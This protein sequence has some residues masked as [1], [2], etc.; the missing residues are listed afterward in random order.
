LFNCAYWNINRTDMKFT[1]PRELS[2]AHPDYQGGCAETETPFIGANGKTFLYVW[3][4][5]KKI[6]FYY[7]FEE[8]L[9]WSEKDYELVEEMRKYPVD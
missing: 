3:H 9:F 2:F 6:H 5:V 7:C 8:D 4:K 1:Y